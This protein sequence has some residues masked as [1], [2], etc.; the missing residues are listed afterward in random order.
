MVNNSVYL[1][2]ILV[3]KMD[4]YNENNVK[5]CNFKK[6]VELPTLH[7]RYKQHSVYNCIGLTAQTLVF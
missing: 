1:F 5:I 2:S 7:L 3:C 4:V 6:S